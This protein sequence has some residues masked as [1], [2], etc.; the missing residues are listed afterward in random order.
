MARSAAHL[1]HCL[2]RHSA[3]PGGDL[4]PDTDLLARFIHRREEAAFEILLARYGPLVMRVCR[5]VL[6]DRHAAEDAFQA[7]FW[8]LARQARTIRRPGALAAWLHGVA[9]RVAL[10]ARTGTDRRRLREEPCAS[11]SPLDPRPDPLQELSARELLAALDE[12][13]QRLPEVYRL[14]VI[15]CCLEGRTQEEAALQLGWSPGSVKG[16]LERG[17][18]RLHARLARR[19]LTMSAVLA[20]AEA[21][22]GIG[23][24][25]LPTSLVV[26]VL[27]AVVLVAAGRLPVGVAPA[28]VAALTKGVLSAMFLVRLKIAVAV[29]MMAAILGLAATMLTSSGRPKP[30]QAAPR[31]DAQK[32][33]RPSGELRP[34]LVALRQHLQTTPWLL[35]K[36][37]AARGVLSVRSQAIPFCVSP[38]VVNGRQ[39]IPGLH[40]LSLEGLVVAK[41]AS[42]RLNAKEARLT[43]LKV[44]MHLH[45]RLA[46]DR[47]TVVAIDAASPPP[48]THYVL[49]AVD[50]VKNTITVTLGEKGLMLERLALARDVRI[51]EEWV[52]VKEQAVITVGGLKLT[53]LKVGMRVFLEL[54][55]R[56]DRLKVKT[57][58]ISE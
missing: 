22:R 51:Q 57:I 23:A 6:H 50:L 16:R 20:V 38:K 7:T 44:G 2:R 47:L 12:E 35:T 58:M 48:R 27:K 21:A 29:L 13:V 25:G 56:G 5:G 33:A 31:A 40:G 4:S 36:V 9:R 8:V 24:G 52:D 41:R 54:T 10:K 49:K 39:S 45:L 43:D 55:V 3:A 46:A 37:D 11:F 28:R 32:G 14:P 15:L 18:A 42:V 26:S 17:R 1:L 30:V 53:D 19:G 34:N